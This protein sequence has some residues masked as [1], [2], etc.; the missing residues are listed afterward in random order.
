M[1]R[2]KATNGN[3]DPNSSSSVLAVDTKLA[4]KGTEVESEEDVITVNKMNLTELKNACDDAVKRV[5]LFRRYWL[6][7][8]LRCRSADCSSFNITFLAANHVLYKFTSV[9]PFATRAIHA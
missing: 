5:S 6:R 8:R 2:K 9:V 7:L 4:A 3:G 1:A